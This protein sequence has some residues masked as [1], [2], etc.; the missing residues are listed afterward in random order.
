MPALFGAVVSLVLI[1]SAVPLR[2]RVLLHHSICVNSHVDQL[3]VEVAFECILLY[4]F[5]FQ[6]LF[7][8]VDNFANI[9]LIFAVEY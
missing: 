2:A 3:L 8:T 1:H 5:V 9:L 6:Y 7:E 4:L